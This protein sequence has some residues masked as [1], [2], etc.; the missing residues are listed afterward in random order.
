MKFDQKEKKSLLIALGF[1]GIY[2]LSLSFNYFALNF[3]KNKILEKKR[4]IANLEKEK[5]MIE[6]ENYL[7]N[8]LTPSLNNFEREF[9]KNLISFK[10]EAESK[11]KRSLEEIKNVIEEKSKKENWLLEKN[12]IV[13][14]NLQVQIKIEK[15]KISDFLKFYKEEFF[16]LRLVNLKIENVENFYLIFFVLE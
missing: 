15:T 12:E 5:L 8:I 11:E 2:L 16:S 13:G 4:I 3:A 6:K 10:N 7:L 1:L 14:N 9:G